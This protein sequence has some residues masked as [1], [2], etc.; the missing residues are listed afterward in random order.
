MRALWVS[1]VQPYPPKSGVLIR[2]HYLLRSVARAHDVDLV[3]FVQRPYLRT[4]FESESAGLEECRR[5][6]AEF[7]RSVTLLPIEKIERPQGQIRT[8]LESLVLPRPYSTR[9]LQ[10]RAAWR[11]LRELRAAHRYDM[12]HFDTIGLAPYQELFA[13]TPSTLGHHNIESHMLLRRASLEKRLPQKAYYWQEGWRLRRYEKKVAPRFAAHVT[14]SEL[15]S[16]RLREVYPGAHTCAIPNG[17]DVEY[18]APGDTPQRPDSLVF[19][20]TLNWYPNISAVLYL[21]REVWPRLKARRPNATLDIVGANAPASIVEA[22]AKAPGVKLLGYVPDI[23][24]HMDAAA[25]Y[26]CPI[27]DGGGTKL[28]V[29]DALS[30]A[31]CVVAHPV[32]CEGIAVTPGVDA[33]FASTP[34]EYVREIVALFDDPE[35]R[36]A[37]GRAAR[38]LAVDRYAFDAI[39]RDL[40]QLF[41]RVARESR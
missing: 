18:L 25:I 11:R 30:M 39:G 6:L 34:E 27:T 33:I 16:E 1:Q 38:K 40:T 9:W 24:P 23:R 32:A 19:V 20:G 29:L 35:R 8:A 36:A 13:D 10:S 37:L 5:V 14:C 22:A 28:K 21:L 26:V 12:A 4:F 41:E 15:D 7:C 2:C 17:V 31:K 3:A